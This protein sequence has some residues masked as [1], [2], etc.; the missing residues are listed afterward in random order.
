MAT[1]LAIRALMG[2]RYGLALIAVRDDEMAASANGIDVLKVKVLAMLFLPKG[3][4][5]LGVMRRLKSA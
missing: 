4:M 1:A 5:R 3:L 2:S